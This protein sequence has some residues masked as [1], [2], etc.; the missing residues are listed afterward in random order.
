MKK[1]LVVFLVFALLLAGVWAGGNKESKKGTVD[2][3]ILLF[4][5]RRN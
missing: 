3:E 5:N 4:K 2:L 1:A